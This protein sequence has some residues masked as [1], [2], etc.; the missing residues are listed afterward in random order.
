L[1]DGFETVWLSRI[2]TL[3]NEE[4]L[5]EGL[6]DQLDLKP[7]TV[8]FE[9]YGDAFVA[10]S[11][12]TQVGQWESRGA[13]LTDLA[14]AKELPDWDDYWPS[15]SSQHRSQLL[16]GLRVFVTECPTCGGRVTADTEVVESCCRS[17]TVVAVCC[18]DCGDRLLEVPHQEPA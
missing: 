10:H 4:T 5:R 2:E 9:T 13:L 11:D 7:E 8:T 3:K 16:G 15:L 1:T 12:G 14:A 17:T 18:E 6:A